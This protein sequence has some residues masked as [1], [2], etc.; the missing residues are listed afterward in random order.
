MAALLIAPSA[1]E[2]PTPL[3]LRLQDLRAARRLCDALLL[4]QGVHL[5]AWRLAG[6]ASTNPALHLARAGAR[7]AFRVAHRAKSRLAGTRRVLDACFRLSGAHRHKSSWTPHDSWCGIFCAAELLLHICSGIA[8]HCPGRATSQHYAVARAS[9]IAWVSSS[10]PSRL[11]S[12]SPAPPGNHTTAGRAQCSRTLRSARAPHR[13]GQHPPLA[14]ATRRRALATTLPDMEAHSASH[15]RT[16]AHYWKNP[17]DFRSTG[18]CKSRQHGGDHA[19]CFSANSSG[20]CDARGGASPFRGR[21]KN[22][23][24]GTGSIPMPVFTCRPGAI[25]ALRAQLAADSRCGQVLPTGLASQQD[26]YDS[27]TESVAHAPLAEEQRKPPAR[28]K[29]RVAPV[30]CHANKQASTQT[31]REA[32][33]PHATARE[34]IEEGPAKGHM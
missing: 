19:G 18:C 29:P 14:T 30:T 33:V 24:N 21:N 10:R 4:L 31:R 17:T 23:S 34:Q 6:I 27:I 11:T 28:S 3:R 12:S 5:L 1:K 32:A 15:V 13:R 26:T 16:G 20:I 22:P 8:L 25:E 2:C 9:S 7:R